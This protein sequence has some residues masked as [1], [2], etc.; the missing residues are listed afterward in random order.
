MKSIRLLLSSFFFILTV[1]SVSIAQESV[2]A[3]ANNPRSSN[4]AIINQSN[5][6][7]FKSLIIPELQPLV[8]S[9]LLQMDVTKELSYSTENISALS[10]PNT[11]SQPIETRLVETLNAKKHANFALI[12]KTEAKELTAQTY[13]AEEILWNTYSSIV[14]QKHLKLNF[15]SQVL[16]TDALDSKY[17]ITGSLERLLSYSNKSEKA[18]PQLF[19]EKISTLS[20]DSI[21]PYSWL[22]FKFVNDTPEFIWVFSPAINKT[23][24]MISANRSDP[25]L[26]GLPE[27]DDIFTWSGNPHAVD[28]RVISVVRALVPFP[29]TSPGRLFNLENSC[30]GIEDNGMTNSQTNKWNF[31]TKKFPA[32][33]GW[34][35]NAA[36]FSPRNLIKI[37]LH[38]LDPYYKDS[39][40]M[41]YL[42]SELMVPIYKI[43][44]NLLGRRRKIVFGSYG[45]AYS[46]DKSKKMLYPSFN[47][48][49][50]YENQEAQLINYDQ[51]T[52]CPNLNIETKL[53][54]FEPIK[55]AQK[56]E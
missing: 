26:F 42:D 31:E 18:I 46:A 48:S 7:T 34:L 40:Q 43:S 39:I 19:R 22:T 54:E 5:F 37:Q 1:F 49:I 24:Q 56:I 29:T 6:E 25:I 50:N 11:K 30:F 23:R 13:P 44:Y 4:Q 17:Q 15:S 35:P 55:I 8:E 41:I 53:K 36:V 52:S 21:S 10:K 20:P 27:I 38:S 14:S 45:L 9:N 16:T 3:N 33:A 47:V 32:G 2:S 12:F 28:A 51:I